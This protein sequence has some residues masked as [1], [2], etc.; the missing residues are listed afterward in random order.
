MSCRSSDV[1]HA[2]LNTRACNWHGWKGRPT[3]SSIEHI[4]GAVGHDQLCPVRMQTT[5]PAGREPAEQPVLLLSFGATGE[6][7]R[8]RLV[9][10]C[11]LPIT[12]ALLLVRIR[13]HARHAHGQMTCEET[14]ECGA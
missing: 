1:S 6:Y 8:L 12:L 2:D 10:S 7:V 3:F 13:A 4:I 14:F 11:V 9:N 5:T